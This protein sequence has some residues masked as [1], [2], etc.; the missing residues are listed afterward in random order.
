VQ[1]ITLTYPQTASVHVQGSMLNHLKSVYLSSADISFPT[2]CAVSIHTD[3]T[4][5]NSEFPP[6]SGYPLPSNYF[7]FTDKNDAYISL[8]SFNTTGTYD[9]IL[10]NVAGYAKLSHNGILFSIT[11]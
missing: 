7:Y 4:S 10:Y 2:L 11:N 6:F 3:N 5:A 8:P 9:V 1:Y